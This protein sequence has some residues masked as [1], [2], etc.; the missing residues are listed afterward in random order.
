MTPRAECARC[1]R[2]SAGTLSG[3]MR[4]AMEHALH[5]H[6]AESGAVTVY[7]PSAPPEHV[8]ARLGDLLTIVVAPEPAGE[9]LYR[10]DG[11]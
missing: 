10:A 5:E 4:W 11:S 3:V 8:R 6:Q 1:P 7:V 2:S 9:D